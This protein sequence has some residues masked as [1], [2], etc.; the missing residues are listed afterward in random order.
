MRSLRLP[1]AVIAVAAGVLLVLL[2]LDVRSWDRTLRTAAVAYDAKPLAGV[3][4][5]PSTAL[6][7][8]WSGGLLSAGAERAWLDAL[9]TFERVY[10]STYNLPALGQR[11]YALIRAAQSRLTPLTRSSDPRLASQ[12]YDLLALLEFREATPGTVAPVHDLVETTLGEL[13]DALRLDPANEA[14][15]ENLE[16][17][18]RFVTVA[19]PAEQKNSRG[20]GG[21]HARY[22][23][24]GYAGPPGA[25]Y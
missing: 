24:G 16:L 3:H 5:T 4:A 20:I 22:P 13:E 12:A 2:A 19:L 15:R 11:Q 17:L 10:T 14:V 8:S 6:P 7:S 9:A 23:K 1:L 21:R 25:G 18:L